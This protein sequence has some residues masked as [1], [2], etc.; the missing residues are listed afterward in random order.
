MYNYMKNP[1][2]VLM[3]A[4]GLTMTAI[5]T[6]A[7][8]SD[9][10][11]R[12]T[13]NAWVSDTLDVYGTLTNLNVTMKVI[14][15]DKNQQIV[16]ESSDYTLQTEGTF[17]SRL[18]DPQREIKF[19]KV[20]LNDKI[21][22]VRQ[23]D[24]TKV[25]LA[26]APTDTTSTGGR[27]VGVIALGIILALL[28][29]IAKFMFKAASSQSH[30]IPAPTSSDSEIQQLALADLKQGATPHRFTLH[31]FLPQKGESV[32]WAFMGVKHFRQGTH[33]EWVGRSSGASVR[34][35]TDGIGLDT[36]YARNNRH[37][38]TRIHADNL[39]FMKTAIDLITGTE[40]R[41]L[42]A[43]VVG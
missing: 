26:T 29:L 25:S 21:T 38:F 1:V 23:Q 10:V 20:V 32:I 36:D 31:G 30:P 22:D 34:V 3:M 42:E 27:F 35:F 17:H 7:E 9:S 37:I 4:V 40:A 2:L 16:T 43:K 6:Q 15:F 33:S 8:N 14:G 39:T 13:K 11:A 12:I 19:V 18:R 24:S 28:L 5:T 41:T